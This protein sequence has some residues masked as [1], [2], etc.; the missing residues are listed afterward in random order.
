MNCKS[1]IYKGRDKYSLLLP[2]D[3]VEKGQ[4]TNKNIIKLPNEIESNYMKIKKLV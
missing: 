3:G 4:I 2:V 1:C